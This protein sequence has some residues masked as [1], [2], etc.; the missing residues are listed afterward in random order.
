VLNASGLT[1]NVS[2]STETITDVAVCPDNTI[3][4]ADQNATLNGLRI[5]TGTT[6]LTT[7]P[8]PIGLAPG[9]GNG[10]VCYDR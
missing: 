2:P 8:L 6:E 9:D 1:N 4:A 5:Y 10:I 7:M 3:I